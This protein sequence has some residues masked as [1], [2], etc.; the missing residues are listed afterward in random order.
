[1]H[2]FNCVLTAAIVAVH[3]YKRTHA[4]TPAQVASYNEHTV[5]LAEPANRDLTGPLSR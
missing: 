2:V 1:M 5:A 4:R 3:L